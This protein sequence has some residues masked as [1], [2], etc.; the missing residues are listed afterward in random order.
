[1]SIHATV[2]LFA[3]KS[4]LLQ[5]HLDLTLLEVTGALAFYAPDRECRPF[6]ANRI[7]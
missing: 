3:L 2:A 1:M 6:A 5:R 7:L 4:I